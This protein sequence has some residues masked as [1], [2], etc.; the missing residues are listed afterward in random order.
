MGTKFFAGILPALSRNFSR[1]GFERIDDDNHGS[2]ED[3]GIQ[4][5][6]EWIFTE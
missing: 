4:A 3:V 6:L 1:A 2:V 5:S